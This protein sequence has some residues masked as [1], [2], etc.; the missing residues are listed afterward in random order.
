MSICWWEQLT[1]SGNDQLPF[2]T[3]T[4]LRRSPCQFP[5]ISTLGHPAPPPLLRQAEALSVQLACPETL[6]DANAWN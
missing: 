4:Q 2:V 5:G 3:N 1:F 6:V